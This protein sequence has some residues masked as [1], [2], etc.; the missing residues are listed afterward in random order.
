MLKNLTVLLAV[1][2]AFA[3]AGCG[4]N[5]VEPQDTTQT[6][7]NGDKYNDADVDFAKNMIPHLSLIHI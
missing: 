3:L 1:T 5:D 4:S 2:A 6:A 7:P